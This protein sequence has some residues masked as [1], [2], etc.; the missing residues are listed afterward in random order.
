MQEFDFPAVS[1]NTVSRL[2]VS[3]KRGPRDI[4]DLRATG[5]TF[6]GK[7]FFR[8][9]FTSGAP[10]SQKIAA[11]KTGVDVTANFD[12]VLGFSDANLRDFS[13]RLSKRGDELTA[14]DARGKL[15][16]GKALIA[17][18]QT[19]P[20]G[21][22]KIIADTTDAGQSLRLVGFYPNMQ[23]GRGRIDLFLDGEDAAQTAGVL[24][25]EDFKVLGDPVVSEVVSSAAG[26]GPAIG[27]RPMDNAR[28]CARC[29][30]S[31]GCGCRSRSAM[32]SSPSTTAICADRC[33]AP[34]CAARS[35]T[36]RRRS[37]SAA[38]TFRCRA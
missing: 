38:R 25:I 23:G 20:N 10:A 21:K 26:D 33:W 15:D 19:E 11:K 37:T 13:M 6:D 1:L 36:R 9:L 28:S 16:G 2:R 24:I 31:I 29:S 7:D 32:A 8:S 34:R 4:L 14:L 22:R 35:T 5:T 30:S 17:I 12:T 27:R 18:L 3:G